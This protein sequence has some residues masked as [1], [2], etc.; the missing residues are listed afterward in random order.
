MTLATCNPRVGHGLTNA[1]GTYYPERLGLVIC[2]NHNPVFQGVWNAFKIFLDPN[3]AAKMQM[4]RK[5]SKFREAF[6]RLFDEELATWLMDEVKLNK[7]RPMLASQRQFWK[8]VDASNTEQATT[9]TSTTAL[10]SRH[11]PRGCTSYVRQYVEP[12]LANYA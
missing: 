12:Y 11:D 10:A 9:P 6:F 8:G 3:T 2:I 4:L 7:R 1:M 5:K